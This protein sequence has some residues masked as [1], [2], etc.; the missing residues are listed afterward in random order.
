MDKAIIVLDEWKT[1][2]K[3]KTGILIILDILKKKNTYMDIRHLKD[4]IFMVTGESFSIDIFMKAIEDLLISDNIRAVI[5]S[6]NTI[7]LY[8]QSPFKL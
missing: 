7:V 5:L 1:V 3:A 2:K 8:R 4:Y 6:K